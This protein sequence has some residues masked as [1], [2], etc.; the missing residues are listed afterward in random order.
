MTR[1]NGSGRIYIIVNADDFGL[2]AGVNEG[3]IDSHERGIVTSTS[4]MVREKAAEPA[5]A[6]ARRNPDLAVGLHVDLGEWY[7]DAASGQWKA[8]YERVDKSD[9]QS[10]Q[11]EVAAQVAE[12]RRLMGRDP[13]HIDSHQHVHRSSPVSDAVIRWGQ[14]LRVPVRHFSRTVR[15]CGEFYGASQDAAPACDRVTAAALIRIINSLSPG[16][17]EIACHPGDDLTLATAYRDQRRLEVAALTDPAVKRAMRQTDAQ[18]VSFAT[19]PRPRG[20]SSRAPSFAAWAREF[21]RAID[22]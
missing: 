9:A 22:R 18:L 10:V 1:D 17:T 4:L 21:L 19:F 12:F 16:V 8:L 3:I 14:R 11:A 6:Y 15:Y 13:T 7:R 20:T 2:S 5:A